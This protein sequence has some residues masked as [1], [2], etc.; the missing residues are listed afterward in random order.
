MFCKLVEKFVDVLIINGTAKKEDK[1]IIVY[2]LISGV[3]LMF[4]IITTLAL[5]LIFGLVIESLVFLISFPLIRTYAGGYHAKSAINCYVFSSIIVALV[6]GFVKYT[7]I[8][9][10][11]IVS[12][13]IIVISLPILIKFAPV[14]ART[15]PLDNI[16]KKYFRKKVFVNL[17]IEF[18][19]IFVMFFL[20]FNKL[21][22]TI[23]LGIL[24][25][26]VLV[27]MEKFM[28]NFFVKNSNS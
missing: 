13:F 10:I 26:A 15:K 14:E 17:I 4:N 12:V 25:S 21:G 23:S 16:E 6:F 24:V 22:Y 9:Y 8:N 27:F 20:D 5:G 19:L 3:K 1:E 2:G 7:P 18:I 11:F 28:L